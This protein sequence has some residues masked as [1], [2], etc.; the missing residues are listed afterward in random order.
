M[1][2]DSG[3]VKEPIPFFVAAAAGT[4]L[5]FMFRGG[6]LIVTA[7]ATWGS[8][9]FFAIDPAGNAIPVGAA[10]VADGAPVLN[11]PEG[12]IRAVATGGSAYTVYGA[13]FKTRTRL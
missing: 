6:Q 9:Q 4:S 1:A 11:F 7:K 10:I 3:P 2:L 5:D 13:P 8:L 12:R